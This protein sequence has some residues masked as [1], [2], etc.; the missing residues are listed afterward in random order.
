LENKL[1]QKVYDYI[2]TLEKTNEVLIKTLK[3]CVAILAESKPSSQDPKEWQ[4]MLNR[5]QETINLG[6]KIISDKTTD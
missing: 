5:F 4:Q 1:N 2:T 6:E 3:Y